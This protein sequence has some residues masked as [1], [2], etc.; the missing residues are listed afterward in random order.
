MN[1]G[2]FGMPGKR[3]T[4]EYVVGSA[5]DRISVPLNMREGDIVGFAL[6]LKEASGAAA[7][8]VVIFFN[9]DGTAANYGVQFLTAVAG[10]VAAGS[11]ATNR[12][13]GMEAG[14]YSSYSGV[15]SKV[16]GRTFWEIQGYRIQFTVASTYEQ[17]NGSWPANTTLAAQPDGP[18]VYKLE[19]V[20]TGG[21]LFAQGSKVVLWNISGN[22]LN[23]P[24]Q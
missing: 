1:P 9:D 4:V 12:F 18:D 7:A 17:I 15:F 20:T 5:K 19:L 14:G 10:V 11:S 21:Q 16:A 13:A 6:Q 2:M 3:D 24:Q 23:L 8:I 22:P